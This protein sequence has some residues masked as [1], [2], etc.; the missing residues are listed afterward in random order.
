MCGSDQHGRPRATI[1]QGC[2]GVAQATDGRERPPLGTNLF[3][4]I[5]DTWLTRLSVFDML[6]SRLLC[7]SLKI[8]DV[9]LNERGQLILYGLTPHSAQ[10]V[11]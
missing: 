9:S 6:M 10:E 5:P 1:V 3:R 7:F 11:A 8:V 2:T 4:S